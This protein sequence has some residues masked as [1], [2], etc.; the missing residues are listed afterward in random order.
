M[1]T[2]GFPITQKGNK[3]YTPHFCFVWFF[4]FVFFGASGKE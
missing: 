1:M 4:V 3:K 2:R